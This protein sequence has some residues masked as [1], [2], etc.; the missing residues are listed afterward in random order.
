MIEVSL[1]AVL[2][3]LGVLCRYGVDQFFGTW[4]QTLP[5]TTLAINIVGSFVAGSVYAFGAYR[6]MPSSL[7]MGLLVGFC[8]GF[9]TFSAYALQSLMMLERGK[10]FHALSYLVASPV[11]GL[12][13]A[14]VPLLIARKI[15]G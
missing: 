10:T 15:F 1:I 14:F 7:H 5:L 12:L 3:V 13:A 8:G 4:N 9:S 2:G 6:A 11:L